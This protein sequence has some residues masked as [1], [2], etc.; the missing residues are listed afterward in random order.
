MYY[1]YANEHYFIYAVAGNLIDAVVF[2]SVAERTFA[3][4][5]FSIQTN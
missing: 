4:G 3:W 2:S 1:I 5:I